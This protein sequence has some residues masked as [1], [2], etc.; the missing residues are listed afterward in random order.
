METLAADVVVAGAGLGGITCALR[1]RELGQDVLLLE[2]SSEWAGWSNSRMSGAR[3]HAAGVHPDSPTA[4]LVARVAAQTGGVASPEV[5]ASWANNVGRSY[6]WL[7]QHGARFVVLRDVPV[8]APIRPN[9]RGEVWSGYGADVTVRRLLRRFIELGGRHRPGVR[10]LELIRG[11]AG[12]SG[13]VAGDTDAAAS[14]RVTAGAVVLADGGF[15]ANN[16]LLRRHAGIRHP[17]HM[18]QRGAAT[19]SG[20]GL[21]MALAAGAGLVNGEALYAHLVHGDAVRRQDLLHYP[22]LDALAAASIVVDARGRRF[23]DESLGGIAIANR[24]ARLDDPRG[25]WI[26]FD[27]RRW[28]TAATK[29]QIVPPNPNLLIARARIETGATSSALAARTGLPPSALRETLAEQATLAPPY[30]AV[31]VAV[32][33]TFTMGGIAIGANGEALS[34]DASGTVPGLYAVGATA[35]GLSGGPTPGYIAGISVASTF[36]LLA[37][38]HAARRRSASR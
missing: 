38:E 10:A 16:E 29:N 3:Y 34:V 19:G 4:A 32:G 9:R 30:F 12:V 22:L 36:G 37:A 23:C 20:D 8:M 13:L 26:V 33:L 5:T 21:Q 17:E 1:A 11:S 2:K 24:L 31:P 7:R 25:A 35:G 18:L 6:A 28:T 14:M 27:Q 15:Q